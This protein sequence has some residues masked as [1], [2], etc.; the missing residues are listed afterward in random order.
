MD[1]VHLVEQFLQFHALVRFS[2]ARRKNL[3]KL[4]SRPQQAGWARGPVP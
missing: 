4:H 1:R 3:R 2:R